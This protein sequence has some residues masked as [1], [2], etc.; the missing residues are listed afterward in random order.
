[1]TQIPDFGHSSILRRCPQITPI[2]QMET[3]T[4]F[5]DL[6]TKSTV[7]AQAALYRKNLDAK[8]RPPL[9]C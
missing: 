2:T 8:P 4:F 9:R 7:Q 5:L 3:T 6:L 1:M